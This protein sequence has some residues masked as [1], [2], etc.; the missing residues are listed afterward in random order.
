MCTLEGNIA[1]LKQG[2]VDTVKALTGNV[3]GDTL[4]PGRYYVAAF[5]RP[6]RDSL[7]VD[8]G[9]VVLHP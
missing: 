7:I 5:V 6:N 2:Q 3:L 9:V 4:A 8:A 1:R